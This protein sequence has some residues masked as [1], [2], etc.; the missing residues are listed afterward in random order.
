MH[1][2]APVIESIF[3][4]LKTGIKEKRSHLQTLWPQ[5]AGL[6]L[7]RHT[8]AALRPGNKLC[9]WADSSVLAHDLSQRYQGTLLKRAQAVLG[10]ETVK[11]IIFRVG[12]VRSSI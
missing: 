5:I 1:P 7:S 11:K 12:D 9:V 2:L 4:E 3:L 10:E 8:Q 6:P